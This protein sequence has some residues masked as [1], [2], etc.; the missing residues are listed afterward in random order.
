M[1][2]MCSHPLRATPPQLGHHAWDE[3]KVIRYLE[4][5]DRKYGSTLSIDN[6]HH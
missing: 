1:L 6:M 3:P 4:Q 2:P 5:V